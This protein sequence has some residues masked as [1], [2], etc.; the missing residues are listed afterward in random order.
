MKI[1]VIM[2]AHNREAYIG[3]AIRSLL[4]Q[5][6]DA[7]LD[8]VVVDDESTDGTADIVA[9]IAAGDPAVRLVHQA[10]AGVATAR[11][12]GLDNIHAAAELVSFLDSDDACA[13]GRF[14]LELPLFRSNPQLAMT[15]GM[16]TLTQKIDDVS[17]SPPVG[18]NTCTLRGVGLTTAIF[19]RAALEQVGRF[20]EELVQAEDFDFLLRFFELSLEYKLLDHVSIFYRR[21]EGN[22]TKNKAEARKFFLRSLILS[23]RRRREDGTLQEIPKFFDINGL[24]EADNALLR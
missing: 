6:A 24:V 23:A 11:N 3:A 2:P 22:M 8:I 15:Y 14:A 16:M 21:H 19:R 5:R 1:S 7:D 12:T 10:K 17:L 20:N 18:A 4:N 13:P 9:R